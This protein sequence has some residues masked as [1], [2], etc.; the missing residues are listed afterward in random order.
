M[1]TPV[2]CPSC[3]VSL[4]LREGFA[5]RV[6]EFKCPKCGGT[7][8]LQGAQTP[9]AGTSSTKYIALRPIVPQGAEA[10]G[11]TP[12]VA[13]G[14]ETGAV[15]ILVRCSGC[16]REI[17]VRPDLAGKKVRCKQCGTINPVPEPS[18]PNTREPASS[19]VPVSDVPANTQ[20]PAA[21]AAASVAMT[22]LAV[23]PAAARPEPRSATPTEPPA[24]AAGPAIVSTTGSASG[25][26]P[27]PELPDL[28]AWKERAEK[29]ELALRSLAGQHAVEKAELLHQ[30][31][32][33]KAELDQVRAQLANVQTAWKS[34]LEQAV[35]A[36]AQEER[37]QWDRAVRNL[38]DRLAAL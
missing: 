9:S 26:S 22:P 15:A 3:G 21:P 13:P 18:S 28:R 10:K 33:L 8:P 34:K 37:A 14:T 16:G 23:A 29:A 4:K 24:A 1:I 19:A 11:S 6:K 2:Q 30:I 7:I 17:T 5:Q 36:W 32:Q 12:A 20:A 35:H 25:P 27:A 38:L 31:A